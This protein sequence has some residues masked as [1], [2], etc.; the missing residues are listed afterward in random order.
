MIP[1]SG[2]GPQEARPSVDP[3]RGRRDGARRRCW[4]RRDRH[5]GITIPGVVV[6]PAGRDPHIVTWGSTPGNRPY[7]PGGRFPGR[8]AHGGV[9]GPG[10]FGALHGQFV[11]PR[12]GG[13]YQTKTRSAA[14]SPP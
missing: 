13:G 5:G 7:G 12:S 11:V 8:G 2:P 9:F 4:H 14:A 10:A 6:R 3:R 1:A